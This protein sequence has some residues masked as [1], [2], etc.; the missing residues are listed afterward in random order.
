M[1]KYEKS[2][3]DIEKKIESMRVG[4][5]KMFD[6]IFCRFKKI[7]SVLYKNIDKQEQLEK[8]IDEAFIL[9]NNIRWQFF[10]EEIG[11][12]KSV[13]KWHLERHKKSYL[14][15]IENGYSEFQVDFNMVRKQLNKLDILVSKNRDK[16]PLH[17][18]IT[19]AFKKDVKPNLNDLNRDLRASPDGFLDD[20]RIFKKYEN[21]DNIPTELWK[22]MRALFKKY[23]EEAK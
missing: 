14:E 23:E 21:N 3:L 2:I 5:D 4:S 1:E 10:D 13:L 20:L 7:E 19:D 16:A 18:G 6:E 15:Q 17:R 12:I 8:R 9:I 11:I 22:D